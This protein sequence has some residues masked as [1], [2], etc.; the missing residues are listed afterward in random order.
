ML[1]YVKCNKVL[2]GCIKGKCPYLNPVLVEVDNFNNKCLYVPEAEIKRLEEFMICGCC[3]NYIFHAHK[4]YPD[5]ILKC[6]NT[7]YKFMR[8]DYED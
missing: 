2:D 1:A 5:R 3:P 6:W 4:I 7:N 8:I